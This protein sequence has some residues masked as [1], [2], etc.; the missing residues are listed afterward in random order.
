MITLSGCRLLN[1][2]YEHV[3]A[4]TQNTMLPLPPMFLSIYSE[5]EEAHARLAEVAT[6][7]DTS[8]ASCR[9][10]EGKLSLLRKKSEN[11]F[12]EERLKV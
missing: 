7:L 5:A 12:G 8:E 2:F 1:A 4:N 11:A 6:K 10:L 9:E 3:F